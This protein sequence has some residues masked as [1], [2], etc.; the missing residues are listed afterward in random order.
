MVGSRFVELLPTPP[1]E[2]INADAAK[3]VE[4]DVN[5]LR[6]IDSGIASLP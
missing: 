2:T 1:Q 4:I 3:I 6:G 5:F